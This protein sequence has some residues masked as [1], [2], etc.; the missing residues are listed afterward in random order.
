MK[1]I[2]TIMPAAVLLS[3]VLCLL[4]NSGRVAAQTK[5]WIDG[6]YT[7]YGT[8]TLPTNQVDYTAVT[9]VIDFA[10]DVSSSGSV[11]GTGNGVNS[12]ATSSVSAAHAAGVKVIVSVG[13]AGSGNAFNSAV[14]LNAAGLVLNIVNYVK[15]YGYD[16][17]DIDWEQIGGSLTYVT[18]ITALRV[19]LPPP[20][21]ITTTAVDG[22]Q[23]TVALV[24]PL[25][26]QVNMMTYDVAGNWSGWVSWYN[27]SLYEYGKA[28]TNGSE[29]SSC[30]DVWVNHFIQAGIPASKIGIG[31]EFG[32]AVWS[33]VTGPNQAP[34]GSVSYDVPYTTIKGYGGTYSWDTQAEASSMLSSRGWATYDDSADVAAKM[35]YIKDKG[36][37]GLII[38]SLDMDHEKGTV[39]RDP[40]LNAIKVNPA[41]VAR[42]SGQNLPASAELSQNYPNPFNP[43]TVIT[44]TTTNSGFVTLRVYNALGQEVAILV[45]ESLGAGKHIVV[46]NASSFPSGIYLYRLESN[47]GQLSRKMLLLK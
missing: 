20:Y 41:E 37:G 26:D 24:A 43:S 12:I 21:I 11:S 30:V 25:L 40:L 7:G 29:A 1:R 15:E 8:G 18:L 3:I 19:A 2:K 31:S 14:T 47:T 5:P 45:H 38:W 10:L 35:A 6:Y 39:G 28:A 46:W 4:A 17:V 42:K 13:G 16:G 27:G 9:M 44:F 33:G 23:K 34:G 32:G 36:L 22:D